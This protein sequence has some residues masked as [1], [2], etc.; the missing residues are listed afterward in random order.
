MALCFLLDENLRG[1]FWHAI[2][3][4][5][6]AG[7]DVIDVLCV[8]HPPAPAL[9]TLDPDLLLWIEAN[10]RVLVTLDRHLPGVHLPPHWQAGELPEIAVPKGP[11]S[12]W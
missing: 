1:P 8:G 11:I 3:Q 6:A 10:A 4:H 9:G 12:H 5:N 7:I 2:Q